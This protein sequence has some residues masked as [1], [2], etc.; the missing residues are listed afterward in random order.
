MT[1]LMWMFQPRSMSADSNRDQS[2][3]VRGSGN[4]A[5]RHTQEKVQH[6]TRPERVKGRARE[7]LPF[8]DNKENNNNMHKDKENFI[9]P[10]TPS[11]K[12]PK[13]RNNK[14]LLE[15]AMTTDMA[16]PRSPLMAKQLP[17]ALDDTCE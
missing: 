2:P 9:I 6:G 8:S 10:Q 5:Q 11:Y 3:R 1:I 7:R 17:V 15:T 13:G 16:K 12:T 14:N 4:S